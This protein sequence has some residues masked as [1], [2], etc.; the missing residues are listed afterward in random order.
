MPGTAEQSNFDNSC[1]AAPSRFIFDHL[2]KSAVSL[3]N[4][5]ERGATARRPFDSG[6]YLDAPLLCCSCYFS[7]YCLR[8]FALCLPWR[9]ELF[10]DVLPVLLPEA[11]PCAAALARV[12]RSWQLQ[13]PGGFD[14]ITSVARWGCS[15]WR[16][17]SSRCCS[18]GSASAPRLCA[19]PAEEHH[20]IDWQ[21]L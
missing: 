11:L 15:N 9:L 12:R 20:L 5:K 10:R 13:S 2:G 6:T 21:L 14:F 16:R 17:F 1:N 4:G 3:L 7:R 8:V 18:S 19:L